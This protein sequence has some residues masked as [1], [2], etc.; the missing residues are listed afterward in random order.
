VSVELIRWDAPGPYDVVFSTRRGGVSEGPFATLNLGRRLG[1]VPERVDEN[2]R[3]LC[4][5]TGTDIDRLALNY[6]RHTAQ[7]NRAVAGRRGE[8]G[9]GL[10]TDE[11]ELP[12]LALGADCA[13]IGLARVNGERPAVAVLHAGRI[14][15]LAGIVEA[16]VA[17][18]GGRVAAVV[19]PAIGPCCYEVGEE[20]AAA[21]RAR[22]GA[23]VVSGRKLDLWTS[24]ERALREAGCTSVERLDLCTACDP[25]RFFS[26]RRDGKPRGGHGVLA[27]VA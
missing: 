24:A 22:F 11:P 10:W 27:R 1:D 5:A 21:Y 25:D 12:L 2:R 14:G 23:D 17:A 4:A 18:L 19:G 6:Q 3:R 7:V 9:D 16:G 15:L 26:Y 8:T 20:V 13:L